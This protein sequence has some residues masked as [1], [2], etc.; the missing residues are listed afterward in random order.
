ML[1][2]I[3]RVQL[4]RGLLE[5]AQASLDQAL[6]AFQSAGRL[7]L[8]WAVALGDRGLLDYERGDPV[9]ALQRL[10]QAQRLAIDAGLDAEHPERLFLQVRSAEMLVEL[11]REAEA[12]RTVRDALAR[13]DAAGLRDTQI[14]PDALGVLA[15]SL[16]Y[17]GRREAALDVMLRAE[18]QQRRLAPAHP[19][20]AVILNDLA[21]LLHR[22]ER[23]EQAQ[24]TMQHAIE[25]HRAIYGEHHPQTL[26]VLAN[27][28]S[29]LRVWAGPAASAREYERLLPLIAKAL[30]P[31]PHSHHVN[32]LGQ[33]ALAQE[34]AGETDTA[35]QTARQ[36]WAMH[37]GLRPDLRP[38]T[39]W[40]AGVLG[41]MLWEHDD[42]T[43]TDY[44]S[45]FTSPHCD[46]LEARTPFTRRVCIA[47]AL[48]AA[49]VGDCA[50][51]AATPP[52]PAGLSAMERQWW[53]AWWWLAR[54]CGQA[55]AARA[56]AWIKAG[57][58]SEPL[59][60]WLARRLHGSADPMH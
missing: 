51:P 40:V 27:R 26:Q 19:R 20:M 2:T 1:G 8:H 57:V 28:A 47:R 35:L 17:Q 3:G 18:T 54:R 15:A 55:D 49:D 21:L 11:K 56:Q 52:E 31:E 24:A 7:D 43:A 13:I 34:E 50:L 44:L 30:G 37:S 6:A 22:L 9:Q 48:H 58:A 14:H 23:F 39:A 38:R 10:Q 60:P 16:Q 32:A 41:L 59:P 4:E 46:A 5:D 33:L 36:A 25:R 42:P 45:A 53:L 12:E 29:L